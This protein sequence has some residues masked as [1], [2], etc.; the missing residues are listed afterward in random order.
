MFYSVKFF[1]PILCLSNVNS[2]NFKK[3][4]HI[5]LGANN[6]DLNCSKMVPSA[7]V[8]ASVWG[9]MEVV[10]EVR[11]VPCCKVPPAVEVFPGGDL[12]WLI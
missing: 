9:E 4:F 10:E 12:G 1:C 2:Y 5:S 8:I 3:I 11:V 6:L 7:P